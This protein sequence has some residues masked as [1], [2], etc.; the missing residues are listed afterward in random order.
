M[1]YM[2]GMLLCLLV[3]VVNV[4]AIDF[5]PNDNLAT[6]DYDFALDEPEAF[7]EDFFPADDDW[8]FIFQRQTDRVHS[9]AWESVPQLAIINT[10]AITYVSFEEREAALQNMDA[11]FRA[12]LVN[13]TPYEQTATCR[14][15]DVMLYTFD[16][17]TNNRPYIAHIYLWRD[18]LE[19]RT[20]GLYFPHDSRAELLTY[21]ALFQ[22]DFVTCDD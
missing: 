15:D 14:A 4:H 6:V 7:T 16:T 1:R 2:L 19:V 20:V 22:P 21:A 10:E 3:G 17:V 12:V 9:V 13:Y 11:Y 18:G 8:T 5:Q